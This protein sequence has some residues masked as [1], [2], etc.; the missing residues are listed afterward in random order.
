MVYRVL[1]VDDSSFF[2]QRLKELINSHPE[3]EVVGAATNGAEAIAMA[4]SL[5]PDVISMDYEMPQLDGISAVRA[6]M[7]ARPVPIVMFSS[8]THEGA[9]VTLDA[10]AAGA[11]DFIPKNLVEVSGDTHLIEQKLHSTLLAFAG[12]HRASPPRPLGVKPHATATAPVGR[13]PRSASAPRRLEPRR[14]PLKLVVIGASTGG[15][16]ALTDVLQVLPA[17]FPLPLVV[18]QHMPKTFTKALAE[19]LDRHC[20]IRVDEADSGDLLQAGRALIAPGGQQLMFDGRGGVK[21]MPGD[22]R[23][24][25]KPSV[26]IA[27]ASAAKNYGPAVLGVVLTGMGSDGCEGAR[28]LKEQGAL[29][30]AQDEASCVVYGMPKAVTAAGL[31]DEV[32]PLAQMGERIVQAV[33]SWTS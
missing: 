19:R 24:S 25:C 6:I 33:H 4:A 22:A 13:T 12:K 23:V 28:L 29:V 18:I 8:L 15:P 1:V 20:Q 30:W 10:M 21:L 16:V 9:R 3:L 11:V 17:N 32:Y 2:R 27:F 7:A 31:T 26:D 5:K 14:H